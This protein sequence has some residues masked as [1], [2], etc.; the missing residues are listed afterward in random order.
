MAALR[1][2]E[3]GKRAGRPVER[4]LIRR[5]AQQPPLCTGV[6]CDQFLVAVE[7]S[8]M[9]IMAGT[10]PNL[11][12]L[13]TMRS[14]EFVSTPT[15]SIQAFDDD[16]SPLASVHSKSR[17]TSLNVAN[18][19][20]CYSTL[21]GASQSG[22]V[23]ILHLV[24]PNLATAF[25]IRRSSVWTSKPIP[26]SD[27]VAIGCTRRAVVFNTETRAI[28][29][30]SSQDSDVFSLD[31][32]PGEF[33][34][35]NGTRSGKVLSVDL[36]SIQ[37]QVCLATLPASVAWIKAVPDG[38]RVLVAGSDGRLAA[39]DRRR[40]RH[41]VQEF[42]RP[43]SNI[44]NA[45]RACLDD[46]GLKLFAHGS[47]RYLRCWDVATGEALI[48]TTT[49]SGRPCC[50]ITWVDSKQSVLM[51]DSSTIVAFEPRVI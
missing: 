29:T 21:G 3:T 39:Y 22:T 20:V 6:C 23:Y 50:P 41:V 27:C 37:E 26:G 14:A 33:S 15:M 18:E 49:G 35:I 4:R 7:A 12:D 36:R 32:P 1:E 16:E 13:F 42:L 31:V 43:V 8:D 38:R 45:P 2:R 30:I 47:D 17:F 46:C 28:S 40:P 19:Y 9:V 51:G 10:N 11:P 48:E 25:T 44:N 24:N 5:L 34:L